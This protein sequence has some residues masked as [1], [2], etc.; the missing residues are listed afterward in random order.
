MIYRYVTSTS[1]GVIG[2]IGIIVGLVGVVGGYFNKDGA[3][4]HRSQQRTYKS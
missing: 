4:S 3:E 2:R 1:M